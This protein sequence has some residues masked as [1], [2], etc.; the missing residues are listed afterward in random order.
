MASKRSAASHPS[1][2]AA[3]RGRPILTSVDA[4]ELVA[5]AGSTPAKPETIALLL[6]EQLIGRTCVIVD[7][8]SA[9]DD[10]LDVAALVVETVEREPAIC[11]AVLASVRPAP[12]ALSDGHRGDVDRWLELLDLFD[13]VGVE[14]LD[15]FVVVGE[16]AESLRTLTGMPPLWPGR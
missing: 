1:H 13:D 9:A 8:T 6:D 2:V 16:R 4:L 10:V 15:W 7:S 3:R 5:L 12:D 11:A 14:L